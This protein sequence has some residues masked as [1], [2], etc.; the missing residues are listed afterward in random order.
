MQ[1]INYDNEVRD[2]EPSSECPECG[3][4]VDGLVEVWFGAS[5]KESEDSAEMCEECA[6]VFSKGY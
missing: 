6:I 2:D 3:A 4:K 5:D 1:E